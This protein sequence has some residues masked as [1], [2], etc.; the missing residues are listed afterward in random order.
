M[1]EVVLRLAVR[2]LTP[3]DIPACAWSG[4]APHLVQVA[5]ALERAERGEV[6]YL[7]V[8]PRSD[9]P[10]AI[11]YVACGRAPDAWDVEAQDGSIM[12]YE[13]MCIL[14]RKELP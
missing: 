9:L 10:V 6:S 8:C 12:R 4:S 14:M 3:Q 7:A 1:A 11:G 2:D 5:R 13:T